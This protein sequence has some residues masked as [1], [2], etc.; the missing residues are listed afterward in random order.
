MDVNPFSNPMSI[1]DGFTDAGPAQ[2]GATDSANANARFWDNLEEM[3]NES[4][5]PQPDWFDAFPDTIGD[6]DANKKMYHLAPAHVAYGRKEPGTPGWVD[7]IRIE[8][9]DGMFIAREQVEVGVG[10]CKTW[11]DTP[12][13]IVFKRQTA[14]AAVNTLHRYLNPPDDRPWPPEDMFTADEA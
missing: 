3:L 9:R 10:N 11:R 1:F 13:S 2:T 4:P 7:L 6:F 5:D 14:H 8:L 12:G